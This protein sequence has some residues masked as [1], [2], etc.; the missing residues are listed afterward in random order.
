MITVKSVYD[1]YQVLESGTNVNIH[2]TGFCQS[3]PLKEPTGAFIKIVFHPFLKNTFTGS[4]YSYPSSVN[5]I[6]ASPFCPAC[7]QC[8]GAI[9]LSFTQTVNIFANVSCAFTESVV[10]INVKKKQ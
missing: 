3:V 6:S 7:F 4:L 1:I 10:I 8:G 2:F 9:N 5:G